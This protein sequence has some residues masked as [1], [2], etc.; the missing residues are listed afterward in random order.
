MAETPQERA[1]KARVRRRWLTLG[2]TVGIAAMLISAL[3]LWNNWQAR[4][5]S[6]ADRAATAAQSHRHSASLLLGVEP[7]KNGRR[8]S[9]TPRREAQAIQSQ[10]IY[11]PAILD[12][13]PAETSG[14]A[15]IE[16]GW[17]DKALIAAR[18]KADAKD[19]P[20]DSRLPILI[21]TRYLTDGDP[22]VDRTLY[23]I[24]YTTQHSLFGGTSLLLSGLS[25]IG[26]V[27]DIATGQKRIDALAAP[28]LTPAQPAEAPKKPA[29]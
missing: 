15:R 27:P 23:E 10:T 29:G 13:K 12:M 19:T 22:Y 7:D 11:F 26:T 17:F 18:R 24:G 20:G 1:E 25:R 2:E 8:L 6:E 21:E 3:T 28:L 5:N 4:T 9:L 14:E 16:R